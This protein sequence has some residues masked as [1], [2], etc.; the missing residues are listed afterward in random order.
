MPLAR[1]AL[2]AQ[3]TNLHVAI[4]PGSLA[5]TQDITR[6]IAREGRTYVISASAILR[7]E[8]LPDDVPLRDRILEGDPLE[9]FHNGGSCVANPDGTWLV[10]PVVGEERVIHATLELDRVY[11]ERQNFDPSGHYARP[12]VLRLTVDRRR[13]SAIDVLDDEG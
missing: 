3:G 10:E 5:N 13:Q 8:D 4:W 11:E 7:N 6:F 2:Y 12:D 1:A 9:S